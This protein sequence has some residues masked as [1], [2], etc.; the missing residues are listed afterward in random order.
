[1]NILIER[2]L[3]SSRFR[4]D[5]SNFRPMVALFE[6]QSKE[7]QIEFIAR[8]K[9]MRN[10]DFERT[11]YWG[12]V[13]GYVTARDRRCRNC[14]FPYAVVVH[15]ITY[16]FRGEEHRHLEDLEVLC[17]PCHDAEHVDAASIRNVKMHPDMTVDEIKL[18]I[19]KESYR[20]RMS[21]PALRALVGPYDSRENDIAGGG[22]QGVRQILRRIQ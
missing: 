2:L 19:L 11:A 17:R 6:N 21:A 5:H 7:D 16:E 12:I 8:S 10:A 14:A 18:W 20:R 9:A 4:W 15:H 13:S 3:E 1:M 22:F